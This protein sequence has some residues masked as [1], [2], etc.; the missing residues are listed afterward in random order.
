[1]ANKE[2]GIF[3]MIFSNFLKTFRPRQMIGTLKGKDQFGNQYYEIPPDP[4]IGKRRTSRWFVPKI[5][6]KFDEEMPSEWESW[7]RGRR[8]TVPTQEEILKNI[9]ISDLKKV[10]AAALQEKEPSGIPKPIKE[11]VQAW[12]KYGEYEIYPG[13]KSDKNT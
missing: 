12:P 1:M 10:N 2:R 4:S 5:K 9:A 13:E 3:R 6:D 11:G 7:L 8:D